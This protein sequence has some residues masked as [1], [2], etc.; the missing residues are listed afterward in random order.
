NPE[1]RT[2]CGC[3]FLQNA[4]IACRRFSKNRTKRFELFSVFPLGTFS[5]NR[6]KLILP[7]GTDPKNENKYETDFS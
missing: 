1:D 7:S 2:P 5:E 6:Q 3:A 4:E